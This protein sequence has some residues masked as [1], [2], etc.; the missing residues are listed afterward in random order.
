MS[1]KL[2]GCFILIL[3]LTGCKDDSLANDNDI[4]KQDKPDTA[5]DN[6][7][8]VHSKQTLITYKTS[9]DKTVSVSFVGDDATV[10]SCVIDKPNSD[11][12]APQQFHVSI[13]DARNHLEMDTPVLNAVNTAA[14]YNGFY[15][16]IVDVQDGGTPANPNYYKLTFRQV[17]AALSVNN[18]STGYASNTCTLHIKNISKLLEGPLTGSGVQHAMTFLVNCPTMDAIKFDKKIKSVRVEFTCL[19]SE[20]QP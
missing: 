18:S 1:K 16:S 14:L 4:N 17:D 13:N 8:S 20:S 7:P 3:S 19:V 9:L 12:K 5:A 6:Y 11:A 15:E 10:S 2:L